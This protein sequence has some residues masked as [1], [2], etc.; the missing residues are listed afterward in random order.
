MSE[1]GGGGDSNFGL[2]GDISA[3]VAAARGF[4]NY[5]SCDGGFS[6]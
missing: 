1:S 6:F 3:S 2:S 5:K 4:S